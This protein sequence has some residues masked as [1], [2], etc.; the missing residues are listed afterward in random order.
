MP[1]WQM[2]GIGNKGLI[3]NVIFK[4]FGKK[5]IYLEYMYEK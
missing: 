3:P 2:A 1:I 5:K 4:I